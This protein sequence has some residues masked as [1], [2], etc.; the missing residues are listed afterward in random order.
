MH[1][2]ATPPAF[3]LSQ[4]QTL[5]LMY[6]IID[7]QIDSPKSTEVDAGV[8]GHLWG[9]PRT[10]HPFAKT[11]AK[12]QNPVYILQLTTGVVSQRALPRGF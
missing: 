12:T 6:Q 10:G 11:D 9:R 5:Q 1:V 2:L 7:D 4:D 8:R 3:D